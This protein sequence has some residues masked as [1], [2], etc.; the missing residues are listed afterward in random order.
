VLG[1]FG[2]TEKDIKPEY[3][4]AEPGRRQ[5]ARRRARRILLRRRISGRCDQRARVRRGAAS[6]SSRLPVPEI[7]KLRAQYSFFAADKIPANTYKGIGDIATISVGAQWVT[8]D[9]Q[10]DALVYE[11][12]K[13][14]WN[15]NTRALLDSGHA[16]GKAIQ[17]ATAIA[18][19]G[20][21][22]HPGAESSTRKQ[23]SRSSNA[24]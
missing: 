1:A 23:A 6:S 5:A 19:A 14:L 22:L 13:A 16:K 10:P 17:K 15:N 4:K 21:P 24:R 20:I 9:K 3:L 8:S 2:I 12:T 18:G 11:I 7:D